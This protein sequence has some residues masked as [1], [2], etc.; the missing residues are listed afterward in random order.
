MSV[1]QFHLVLIFSSKRVCFMGECSI[2]CVTV[3]LPYFKSLSQQFS[4]KA[5]YSVT[6]ELGSF[7][8][9]VHAIRLDLHTHTHAL[10]HTHTHRHGHPYF[11]RAPVRAEWNIHKKYAPFLSERKVL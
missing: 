8:N 5:N 4:A 11:D 7:I 1:A 9:M 6:V 10:S 3:F 2:I